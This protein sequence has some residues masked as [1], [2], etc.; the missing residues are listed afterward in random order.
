MNWTKLFRITAILEG[1][2][3]LFLLF[4]GMPLKY[5]L[6]MPM[7]NKIGGMIHG[8]LFILY[9]LMIIPV[10]RKLGWNIKIIFLAVLASIIPFGTFWIE[11]KYLK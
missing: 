6:D 4:I 9:I 10:A 11:R 5:M 2:S 7:P 1:L 8:V 3:Y